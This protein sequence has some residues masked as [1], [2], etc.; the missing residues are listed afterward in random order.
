MNVS[1]TTT[2]MPTKLLLSWGIYEKLTFGLH[3]GTY[4]AGLL[5]FVERY[6]FNDWDFLI[7]LFILVFLDTIFGCLRAIKEGRF[8][9][10]VGLSGFALKIIILACTVFAIG[11]I[12]NSRIAGESTWFQGYV[13][14]GAFAIMLGFEGASVLKNLYALKPS[15]IIEYVL[16]K[17]DLLT[18]IEKNEPKND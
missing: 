3:M 5:F 18:Y 8:K 12:D 17:L 14:A 2:A 1:S 10:R 4:G 11:V 15:P 6:V 13:D 16:K 9:V 7:S